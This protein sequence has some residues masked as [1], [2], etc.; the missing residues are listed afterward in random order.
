V[1]YLPPGLVPRVVPV[2]ERDARGQDPEWEAMVT[3]LAV[4]GVLTDLLD[5]A[6]ETLRTDEQRAR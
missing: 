5:H 2:C 4:S 6:A 3:H 1:P